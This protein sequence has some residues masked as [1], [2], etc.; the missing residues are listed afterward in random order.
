VAGPRQRDWI[1][2]ESPEPVTHR[3][4]RG[5]RFRHGRAQFPPGR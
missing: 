1:D 5:L 3:Q 2:L 4:A